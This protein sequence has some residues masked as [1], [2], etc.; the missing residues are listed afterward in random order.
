MNIYIGNLPKTTNE[1]AIRKLFEGYGEVTEIKLIKE[2]Q[3]KLKKEIDKCEEV[4]KT[5]SKLDEEKKEVEKELNLI[6]SEM[7]QNLNN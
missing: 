1:E 6:A 2:E 4:L 7:F 5:K 3:I